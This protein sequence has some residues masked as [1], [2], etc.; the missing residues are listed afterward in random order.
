MARQTPVEVVRQALELVAK[1]RTIQLATVGPDATPLASYAPFVQLDGAFFVYLSRLA[2]HAQN[3]RATPLL[4]AMLIRDEADC[5][6]I[7]AR[8]R[9]SFDCTVTEHARD[10]AEF[11]RALD[12]FVAQFGETARVVRARVVNPKWIAGV[13]REL[14]DFTL[15]RLHPNSARLV[16]GFAR[17]VDLGDDAMAAVFGAAFR[18]PPSNRKE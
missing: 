18:A 10:S 6:E 1:M 8:P 4:S 9:L 3:L 7:F 12:C 11:A 14:T 15:F 5:E 17:A 2:Q 13:M 16:S